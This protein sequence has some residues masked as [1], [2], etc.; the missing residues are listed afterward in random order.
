[1]AFFLGMSCPV[2]GWDYAAHSAINQ[3][4]L[5]TLPTNFPAFVRTPE[6]K[7]RIGF[8]AGEPDRWRN[9]PDLALK[10][11]NGPE[12]YIDIED[13]ALYGL[14]AQM[15]PV[16]RYDFVASL[17]L[18]RKEN[19]EKFE[20]LLSGKNDDHTRELVGL[21]PW[22]M[23]EMYGKLKSG[24]SYL[25][26][27]REEGG[28]PEEIANAEAN[29]IYIMGVM[30]HLYGDASQPLHVTVHHHGWVGPN[31]EGFSTSRGIHSWIDGGYFEKTGE[32]NVP[33]LA[34]K[35][36]PARLVKIGERDAH[37]E[38][39]F[40]A[41]VLFILEQHKGVETVYRLD[42]EG[43]LT[44]DGE[45]GREGRA[46]LEGQLLRSALFL[47]DIWFTAWQQAPPD[48]FLKGQ[49]AKRAKGRATAN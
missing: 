5:E 15:L 9:T 41:G 43:K 1:M 6:A 48:T 32:L 42:K 30:G 16:F 24:F 44:G 20:G 28:T 25:K 19:P 14:D 4:A 2:L 29:V 45:K 3:V 36:R 49:L 8:L 11:G 7:G 27:Y 38:E 22:G 46:F 31:P 39:I 37:P 12:H 26:A 21:L 33:E 35:T 40:Q 47:G 10:H 17:A 18:K 34:K 13:L 23:A